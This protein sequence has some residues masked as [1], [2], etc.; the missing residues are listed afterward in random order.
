MTVDPL[1]QRLLLVWKELTR[2]AVTDVVEVLEDLDLTL[3]QLKLLEVIAGRDERPS[4]KA[5]SE[6]LGCSLASA[7]R[8]SDAL[9]RRGL[10]ERRE[11][12]QDRRVKRLALTPAG[13]Q[14]LERI[15]TVRL[16]AL[17]RFAAGL[18]PEQRARLGEAL[19]DVT[20][21]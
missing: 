21:G 4:V 12:D 10:L 19:D 1:A 17:E 14:A 8:G 13:A 18:A 20:G 5:L 2:L 6:Q 16:A 15:D 9:V 11:D 3:G 7:S